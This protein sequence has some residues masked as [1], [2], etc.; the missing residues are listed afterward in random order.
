MFPATLFRSRRLPALLALAALLAG[1]AGLGGLARAAGQDGMEYVSGVG[2]IDWENSRAVASGTGAPPAK[3]ANLA[4]A[5]AAARRAAVLDARR[6]LLEVV[7]QVRVDSETTVRNLIVDNDRVS[8]R[9]QG[10]LERSQI[11]SEQGLA[12]GSVRVT[13]S[14]ALTGALAREVLNPG[15]TA[16]V[17]PSGSADAALERRVRV[18]EARVAALTAALES[19]SA[20]A[21]PQTVAEAPKDD[22]RLRQALA[23]LDARLRNLENRP[24]GPA[25]TPVVGKTALAIPAAPPAPPL[26]PA[27]QAEADAATGLILDARGTGFKP[28][29]RPNIVSGKRVLYPSGNV[30]FDYGVNQGFVRYYRD[31]AQAQQSARAGAAPRI[32]KATAVDGGLEVAGSDGDVLQ[33]ILAK[34]GNFMDRCQVV[35]VF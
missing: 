15:Q 35:V 29:L 25:P 20:G 11:V 6:N 18:L 17:A 30:D 7:G 28:T 16:A 22:A 9:V 26:P 23:Q 33:N 12:D 24:Q 19:L 32:V 14:V 27:V 13:V 2:Y 21:R 34:Q 5:R 3:A 1:L 10:V 31:L 8:T 4:Q